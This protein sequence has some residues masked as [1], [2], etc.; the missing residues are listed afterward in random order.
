MIASNL[1]FLRTFAGLNQTE[2]ARLFKINR[3]NID[4]YERSV[5][6]PPIAT[7]NAI[8]KHFGITIETLQL[9]DIKNNPGLLLQRSSF[10][11]FQQTTCA[12]IIKAKD[13]LIK[14]QKETIEFLKKQVEKLTRKV[15]EK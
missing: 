13:E 3:G 7:L 15:G 10:K 4:S 5:A 6:K 2:F 9:E 14:E 11:D 12:E 1:K 8:A